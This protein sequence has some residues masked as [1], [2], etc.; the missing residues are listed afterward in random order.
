MRRRPGRLHPP[1]PRL[2]ACRFRRGFFYGAW[3]HG[4]DTWERDTVPASGC[5]RIPAAFLE[6]ERRAQFEHEFRRLY[7]FDFVPV[8]RTAFS[9]A[10][11]ADD[12]DPV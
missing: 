9:P 11:L 8:G 1:S 2:L 5:P 4:D 12:S 7:C 10:A 6:E 3:T